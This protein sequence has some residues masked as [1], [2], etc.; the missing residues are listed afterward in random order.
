M[1]NSATPTY[2]CPVCNTKIKW[3]DVVLDGFF[4]DILTSIGE[5]VDSVEIQPDGTW[6]LPVKTE[7]ASRQSTS[8]FKRK[9]DTEVFCL[10]DEDEAEDDDEDRPLAKRRMLFFD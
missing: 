8:T 1:M 3:E 5:E 9:R 7:D 6:A 2:V 10:D 4:D